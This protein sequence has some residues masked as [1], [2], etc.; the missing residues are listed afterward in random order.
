MR[1]SNL[2]LDCIVWYVRWWWYVT[3]GYTGGQVT[4]HSL[5]RL[6][7]YSAVDSGMTSMI[8]ASGEQKM[9]SQMADSVM[10]DMRICTTG[11]ITA[12]T[13]TVETLPLMTKGLWC[14]TTTIVS[15]PEPPAGVVGKSYLAYLSANGAAAL[16]EGLVL[17]NDISMGAAGVIKLNLEICWS[18]IK[19]DSLRVDDTSF[20]G[21]LNLR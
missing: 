16:S 12:G 20:N 17:Q 9:K 11:V 1:W 21:D 19:P 15:L 4:Q 13:R 14:P 2:T 18:E 3:T 7:G 8:P 10:G 5:Y 6:R